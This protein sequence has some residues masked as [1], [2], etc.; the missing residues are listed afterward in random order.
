VTRRIHGPQR[1]VNVEQVPKT[2]MRKPTRSGFRGRLSWQGKRAM[3]ATCHS[4]GIL[5]AARV[6][7]ESSATREVL[8]GG[9]ID[10]QLETRE[11]QTRPLG[12][13]DGPVRPMKPV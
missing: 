6:Y 11:G 10:T 5:M 13:A 2:V 8:D 9:W 1:V 7:R 12:M 3:N 4:A